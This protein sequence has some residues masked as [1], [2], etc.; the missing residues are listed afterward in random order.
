MP[1]KEK[2]SASVRK[3][4]IASTDLLSSANH[5]AH[6]NIFQTIEASKIAIASNSLEQHDYEVSCKSAV[7]AKKINSMKSA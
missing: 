1:I 2:V 6:T 7:S 5:Q 4:N 3:E